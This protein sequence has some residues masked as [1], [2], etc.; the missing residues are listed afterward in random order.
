MFKP[1]YLKVFSGEVD[2]SRE[3]SG[4]LLPKADL[5]YLISVTEK[6]VHQSVTRKANTYSMNVLNK[7]V[8]LE[9]SPLQP[10][11]CSQKLRH[12]CERKMEQM[13]ATGIEP[14]H[15]PSLSIHFK[16]F[17]APDTNH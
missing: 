16:D 4:D 12:G 14:D 17:P 7:P 13:S 6:V 1:P 10:M 3:K 11:Q 9:P 8:N 2:I 5:P 15:Q